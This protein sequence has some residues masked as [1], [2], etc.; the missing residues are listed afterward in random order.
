LPLAHGLQLLVNS[1]AV[2]SALSLVDLLG[3]LDAIDL[4][5]GPIDVLCPQMPVVI[6]LDHLLDEDP[7]LIPVNLSY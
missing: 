6:F 7:G 4:G 5:R 2:V 1:V 3:P